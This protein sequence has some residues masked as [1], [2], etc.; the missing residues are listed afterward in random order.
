ML[1]PIISALTVSLAASAAAADCASWT[2]GDLQISAPWSRATIAPDRPAVLYLTLTN[3]GTADDAVVGLETPV[4]RMPMLH[5]T[6]VENGIASMPHLSR[7][8]LPAGATVA[9]APGGLHGML[10]SLTQ[11]LT[12]GESYPLTLTFETAPPVTVDVQILALGARG[13][14]C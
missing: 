3:T 4:S 10:A 9:L 12:Q 7:V 5:E 13:P 14:Q 11:G 2:S 8:P 1:R 6:R